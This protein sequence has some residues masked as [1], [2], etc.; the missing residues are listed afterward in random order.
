MR[1]LQ[2]FS[3]IWLTFSTEVSTNSTEHLSQCNSSCDSIM[4]LWTTFSMLVCSSKIRFAN[5]RRTCDKD[6]KK[7]HQQMSLKEPCEVMLWSTWTYFFMKWRLL[8]QENEAHMLFSQNKQT[9]LRTKSH[10][11]L[12][13]WERNELIFGVR[14]WN[15]TNIFKSIY[16]DGKRVWASKTL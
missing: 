1:I 11:I 13:P 8:R 3:P 10:I 14:N 9:N 6:A 2:T 4:I 16:L 12:P 15:T 7:L 5:W